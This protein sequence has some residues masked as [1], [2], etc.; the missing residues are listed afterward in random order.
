[1][2]IGAMCAAM[3]GLPLTSTLLATAVAR[4][5]RPERHAARDRRGRRGL[6]HVGAADAGTAARGTGGARGDPGGR[7]RSGGRLDVFSRRAGAGSRAA[8]GGNGASRR[9]ERAA[10]WRRD[11]GRRAIRQPSA[12]SIGQPMPVATTN[13]SMAGGAGTS[14]AA[15][16]R[17]AQA[18]ASRTTNTQV[19][20]ALSRVGVDRDITSHDSP[21][22]E[23]QAPRPCGACADVTETT[24]PGPTELP[25]SEQQRR[26]VWWR[27]DRARGGW[28]CSSRSDRSA[29]R[30]RRSRR[31]GRR[32]RGRPS[33]S[34]TSWDRSSSRSPA[35]CS[36]A[37][38]STSSTAG[39][40]CCGCGG[41]PPRGSRDGSTGRR[42]P[43]SSRARCSSTSA[44]SRA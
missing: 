3:L 42:R 6:R 27:P 2:G 30:W 26:G 18:R 19:R 24:A 11:A 25:E 8:A 21:I 22:A 32:S 9:A 38:P 1:M 35:T 5:G 44:R 28:A 17:P 40:R 20:R 41:G 29:S 12:A 43:S 31:S 7:A 4:H 16:T 33:A 10:P 23:S 36:S 14:A 37:R 13:G 15:V 34:P 39:T